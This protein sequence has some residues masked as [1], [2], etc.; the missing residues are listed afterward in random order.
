MRWLVA[1]VGLCAGAAAGV[2]LLLANPLRALDR[3]FAL[4][5]DA[6]FGLAVPAG[7]ERGL[8]LAP[9]ALLGLGGAG[10]GGFTDPAL[11]YARAQV[12]IVAPLD[13]QPPAI[14]VKL[15][16]VA[17]DNGLLEGRLAMNAAWVL[18]WPGQ[19]G[20]FLV[21]EDDHWPRLADAVRSASAGGAFQP[22]DARYRLTTSAADDARPAVVLGGTGAL[23]RARGL[24]EEWLARDGSGELA[25][26]IN[27]D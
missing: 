7:A 20:V 21:G 25:L 5:E 9:G 26:R 2:A 18:F 24:Y 11:R 14:G 13:G 1:I 4:A 16:S 8:A 12:A 15:A 17:R 22:G 3:P 6:V 10:A 27:Q 23:G 19:G